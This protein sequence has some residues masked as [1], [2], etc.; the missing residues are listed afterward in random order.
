MNL[1]DILIITLAVLYSAE[2]ISTKAGPFNIFGHLRDRIPLGGLTSCPWCLWIWL[3]CVF[4]GLHYLWEPA[5]WP[6]AISGGAAALRS[7]T[8]LRHE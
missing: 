2:V 4:I 6:F 5:I 1:F 7:Y 8:G 3:A